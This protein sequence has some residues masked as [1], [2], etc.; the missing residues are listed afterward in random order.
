MRIFW[1]HVKEKNWNFWIF[2]T[3]K[4]KKLFNE[5]FLVW[6]DAK[7]S[8]RLMKQCFYAWTTFCSFQNNCRTFY[9]GTFLIWIWISSFHFFFFL[10]FIHICMLLCMLC[11][12]HNGLKKFSF[13]SCSGWINFLFH[14]I[15]LLSFNCFWLFFRIISFQ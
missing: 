5:Q 12:L 9:D 15:S 8:K 3:Q 13:F 11:T 10:F 7:M 2:S 4:K 14:F 1:L 6:A